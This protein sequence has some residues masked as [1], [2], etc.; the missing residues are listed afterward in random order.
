MMAITSGL[1][2]ANTIFDY[3]KFSSAKQ[4][5][6][7]QPVTVDVG[8]I[9]SEIT[10][11]TSEG[12]RNII[13]N[14][15][16]YSFQSRLAQFQQNVFATTENGAQISTTTSTAGLSEINITLKSGENILI[17]N[18]GDNV[19]FSDTED[20]GI[21]IVTDEFVKIYDQHG[22]LISESSG[23][24]PLDGSDKGDVIF[25]INGSNVNGNG[26]NDTIFTM[27]GNVTIDAGAG[28]DKVYVLDGMGSGHTLNISLGTGNDTFRF[29]GNNN[30]ASDY[31]LYLDGGD[32]NDNIN[33]NRGVIGG[34]IDAGAG[35]DSITSS[36]LLL[37]LAILG[38]SGN[39]RIFLKGISNGSV[40]ADEGTNTVSIESMFS[41]KMLSNKLSSV[42]IMD[43]YLE[44][45][46]IFAKDTNGKWIPSGGTIDGKTQ[47]SIKV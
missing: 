11:G 33:I 26:G 23:G 17:D 9:S 3:F 47:L 15:Q 35:D 19:R 1:S 27:P 10:A 8:T 20:G 39:D 4:P 24:S 46:H 43:E 40:D 30:F 31:T 21:E 25:N 18:L 22:Q 6:S 34:R 41:S 36:E 37:N 29:I 2:P 13:D 28:N 44:N 32:G 38:G 7:F 45:I 42:N 5:D 14:I 12:I 16:T